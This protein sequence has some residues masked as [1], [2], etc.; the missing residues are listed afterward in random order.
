MKKL[1]CLLIFAL[2]LASCDKSAE[3]D[4]NITILGVWELISFNADN[5]IDI[6]NDGI[7]NKDM[8]KELKS[9]F[10]VVPKITFHF[11]ESGNFYHLTEWTDP[12]TS[13]SFVD[14]V[15][16]IWEINE[17]NE[18]LYI[19]NIKWGGVVG[20]IIQQNSKNILVKR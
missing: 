2:A 18:V 4:E 19:K 5:P 17:N 1:F 3:E 11:L 10:G 15:T 6:D 12:K 13:K 20:A 8:L 16:G 7:Y 9:K 14:K